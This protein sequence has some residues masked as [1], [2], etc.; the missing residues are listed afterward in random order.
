MSDAR[1]PVECGGLRELLF[2][3]DHDGE[4]ERL[5]V[6]I[7]AHVAA[8]AACATAEAT[9]LQAVRRYREIEPAPLPAARE[10]RQLD[11]VCPP[12]PGSP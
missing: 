4:D 10:R 11:R 12:A 3:D 9:L 5:A 2:G 8:C 6:A 1:P 7:A